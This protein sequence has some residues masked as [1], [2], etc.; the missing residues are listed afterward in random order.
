MKT[1]QYLLHT[2]LIV[3]SMSATT[4]SQ[5]RGGGTADTRPP[6]AKWQ[7]SYDT[8]RACLVGKAGK[9]VATVK[10]T[11]SQSASRFAQQ[12][13]VLK[14]SGAGKTYSKTSRIQANGRATV[15]LSTADAFP[16]Q[17]R[18]QNMACTLQVGTTIQKVAC[19]VLPVC[20]PPTTSPTSSPTSSPTPDYYHDTAP[21]SASPTHIDPMAPTS[22]PTPDYEARLYD[23]S[24]ES[25]PVA[26]PPSCLDAFLTVSVRHEGQPV[27]GRPADLLVVAN[28]NKVFGG[29]AITDAE[30]VATFFVTLDPADQTA[31]LWTSL[32]VE[33]PTLP[34]R[35][36]QQYVPVLNFGC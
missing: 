30:G 21:P 23:V 8:S 16:P 14:V 2:A 9:V 18:P 32:V 35:N 11:G 3:A 6:I 33:N 10:P 19:P 12:T 31:N 20:A 34:Y 25:G 22:A 4:A 29:V 36:T 13:V 24:M 17:G 5:L 1:T 27:P 15:P 7:V 28:G 26:D